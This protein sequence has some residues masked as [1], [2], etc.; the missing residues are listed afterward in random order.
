MSG[1]I[2]QGRLLVL[3]AGNTTVTV[4]VFEGE[5]LARLERVPHGAVGEL[6]SRLPQDGWAGAALASVIPSRNEILTGVARRVTGADPLVVD[7][8]TDLGIAVC[9]DHPEA[10]GADR[11]ANA[12]AAWQREHRAVVVADVGTAVSVSAVDG[13]GRY[14]GGAIA[15]GPEVALTGLISRAERLPDPGLEPP[16]SAI[17]AGTVEAMRAGMAYG[18]AGLVDRLAAETLRAL[19]APDGPVLLTGGHAGWLD[20]FLRVPHAHVPELTLLGL[21]VALLRAAGRA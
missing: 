17:G 14:V 1:D 16:A 5:R 3:D 9:V 6:A 4:G 8:T 20:P 21:R 15:P 13:D 19:G 10:T 7:H 18:F 2:A 11:L 12:A